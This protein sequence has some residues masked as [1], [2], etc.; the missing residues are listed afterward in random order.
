MKGAEKA[1][2]MLQNLSDLAQRSGPGDDE[3]TVIFQHRIGATPAANVVKLF[4][5]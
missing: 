1:I 5:P 4:R 2:K 3:S